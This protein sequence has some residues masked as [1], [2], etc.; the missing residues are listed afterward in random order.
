VDGLR[1]ENEF[2]RW[3]ALMGVTPFTASSYNVEVMSIAADGPEESQFAS[4]RVLAALPRVP[5]ALPGK[6][7]FAF[8]P[9]SLR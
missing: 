4:A 6:F 3:L 2:G 9:Q 7:A 1:S 8:A 5:A